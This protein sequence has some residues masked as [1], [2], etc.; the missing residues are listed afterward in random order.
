MSNRIIVG[1]GALSMKK[2]RYKPP[3]IENIFTKTEISSIELSRFDNRKAIAP[4]IMNKPIAKIKP[5]AFKVAMIAR[6]NTAN[7]P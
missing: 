6:D 1:A 2:L 7:N 3:N 4:G 5:T